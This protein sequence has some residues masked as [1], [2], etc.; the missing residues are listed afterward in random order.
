MLCLATYVCLRGTD[1]LSVLFYV[2]VLLES[3]TRVYLYS[4]IMR[5]VHNKSFHGCK[6]A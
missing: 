4:D 1:S 6:A 5:H 3:Q 2:F